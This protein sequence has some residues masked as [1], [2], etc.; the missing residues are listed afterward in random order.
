MKNFF[1]SLFYSFL[2]IFL[3]VPYDIY[4][5][6]C[7]HNN[8][9]R[10]LKYPRKNLFIHAGTILTCFLFLFQWKKGD[11][12]ER[13]FYDLMFVNFIGFISHR[14]GGKTFWP[15]KRTKWLREGWIRQIPSRF[16]TLNP[17]SFPALSFTPSSRRLVEFFIVHSWKRIIHSSFLLP[18]TCNEKKKK[19]KKVCRL[20]H[21]SSV[22]TI[23]CE[24]LFSGKLNGNVNLCH[25][26]C[27]ESLSQLE[28]S[29]KTK[30]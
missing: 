20:Q 13:K 16:L 22:F 26:V 14:P 30:L 17:L 9:L 28:N 4:T 23:L 19:K 11:C 3:L 8:C 2:F 1:S 12:K 5:S 7:S 27:N 10:R 6:T 25:L 21:A 29:A 18:T 24:I 15:D